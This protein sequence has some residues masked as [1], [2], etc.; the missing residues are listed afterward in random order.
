MYQRN[1]QYKIDFIS[2]IFAIS[3]YFLAQIPI[4]PANRTVLFAKCFYPNIGLASI[5][6]APCARTARA[7][8]TAHLPYIDSCQASERNCDTIIIHAGGSI[9]WT[10]SPFFT[11][12][13]RHNTEHWSG[14]DGGEIYQRCACTPEQLRLINKSICHPVSPATRELCNPNVSNVPLTCDD[15]VRL[16]STTGYLKNLLTNWNHL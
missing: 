7:A 15:D 13:I 5:S 12:L 14:S 10:D 2:K 1:W 8:H 4:A 16:L 9:L 3:I 6:S 11:T